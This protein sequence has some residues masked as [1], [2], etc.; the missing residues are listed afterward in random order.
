MEDSNLKFDRGAIGK[1]TGRAP[2][3]FDDSN[4]GFVSFRLS[5][6][7]AAAASLKRLK[8]A[9]YAAQKNPLEPKFIIVNKLGAMDTKVNIQTGYFARAR[10]NGQS[11]QLSKVHF[12]KNGRGVCGYRPHE[13]MQF[14]FNRSYPCLKYV[15]CQKCKDELKF[16]YSV[17]GFEQ[18]G[19]TRF[20]PKFQK[21]PLG[22]SIEQVVKDCDSQSFD[23]E[24]KAEK[25]G[26]KC[27]TAFRR[28]LNSVGGYSGSQ[29]K[30]FKERSQN[31]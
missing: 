23:T 9:G 21:N 3:D 18:L 24:E 17:D 22:L 27:V 30:E 7:Q 26:R 5:T 13:T 4:P 11:A 12:V 14:Q 10:Q 8:G 28:F 1:V 25:Y 20:Y 16:A 15:E 19:E 29:I 2:L 31:D 6:A